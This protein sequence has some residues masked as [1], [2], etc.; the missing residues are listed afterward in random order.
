MSVAMAD[1]VKNNTAAAVVPIKCIF[2]IILLEIYL[3]NCASD[4]PESL[5][6]DYT[7]TGRQYPRSLHGFQ[8]KV[9][10]PVAVVVFFLAVEKYW[11]RRFY[12][13]RET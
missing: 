13:I 7:K 12:T 5:C 8:P 2:I 11:S 9:I 4:I 1:E 3:P 6:L 10:S